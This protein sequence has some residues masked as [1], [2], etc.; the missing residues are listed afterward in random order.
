MNH[1]AEAEAG[2]AF[3]QHEAAAAGAGAA[4]EER[5]S[6]VLLALRTLADFDFSGQSLTL[7]VERCAKQFLQSDVTEVRL[8]AASTCCALLIPMILV[9]R[10]LLSLCKSAQHSSTRCLL[11]QSYDCLNDTLY[12]RRMHFYKR[13]L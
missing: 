1:S 12:I 4:N 11:Y 7:I 10:Y 2:G 5:V 8:A 13:V 3:A 9:R 6:R